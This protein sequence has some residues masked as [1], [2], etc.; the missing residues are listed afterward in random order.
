MTD[1]VETASQ[2]RLE[3]EL[4]SGLDEVNMRDLERQL[5]AHRD[6]QDFQPSSPAESVAEPER[7]STKRKQ[8]HSNDYSLNIH[9][10]Q[11]SQRQKR[12]YTSRKSSRSNRQ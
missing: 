2:E 11:T 1:L 6:D 9:T 10:E 7:Q 3:S 4:S 12:T 8:P 5:E